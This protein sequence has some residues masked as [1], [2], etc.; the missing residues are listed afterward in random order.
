MEKSYSDQEWRDAQ[1][2]AVPHTDV[3]G[4][5]FAVLYGS[6]A[7]HLW[8]RHDPDADHFSL[9][10]TRSAAMGWMDEQDGG[11]GLWGMNDAGGAGPDDRVVAWFQVGTSGVVPGRTIPVQPFL[12]CAVDVA[13]QL[14]TVDLDGVLLLLPAQQLGSRSDAAVASVTTSAWFDNLDPA[15][16]R[17]V[18][19][20][21]AVGRS[22]PGGVLEAALAEFVR[23]R[24]RV[25][26][27]PAPG[28]A[29]DFGIEPPFD[30]SFWDGPVTGVANL[31]GDLIEWAP[32]AIGWLAEA[33]A[34]CAAEHGL[35]SPMLMSV[36]MID[37]SGHTSPSK[38]MRKS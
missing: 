33:L 28:H 35:A 25:L 16:A 22:A 36:R 5:L 7:P 32:D 9:F 30:D 3:T 1:P 15:G 2:A 18:E 29:C 37:T 4:T 31:R 10:V 20:R 13:E 24:Q 26:S 27:S 19:V 8:P 6:T 17:P 34:G 11:P 38:R 21:L 23:L 12:R 14:G